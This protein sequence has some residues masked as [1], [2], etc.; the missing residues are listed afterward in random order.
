MANQAIIS[1]Y[2]YHNIVFVAVL[3]NPEKKVSESPH[4]LQISNYPCFRFYW[5]VPS[6]QKLVKMI[7]RV[8]WRVVINY[9][10]MKICI[11]LPLYGSEKRLIL[12]FGV[13]I[14]SRRN[15]TNRGFLIV[16]SNA[17]FFVVKQELSLFHFWVC[18]L[19][20]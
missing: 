10:K 19:K 20:S 18:R 7:S 2:I 1:V 15:Q 9:D 4:M 12:V 5:R 6:S 14:E 8:I 3:F 17:I 16:A 13:N 11:I